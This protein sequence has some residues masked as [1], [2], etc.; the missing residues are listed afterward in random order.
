M[1]TKPTPAE[2]LKFVPARYGIKRSLFR[3]SE[4]G[5]R[6]FGPNLMLRGGTTADGRDWYDLEGGPMIA[7]G[8]DMEKLFGAPARGTIVSIRIAPSPENYSDIV[9]TVA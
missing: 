5:Y 1:G 3:Q 9:I 4:K 8:D 6:L 2:F 7:V